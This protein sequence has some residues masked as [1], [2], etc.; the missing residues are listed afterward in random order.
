MTQGHSCPQT[1]SGRSPPQGP[2]GSLP[3]PT[4]QV[5]GV[6]GPG[7]QPAWGPAPSIPPGPS[8]QPAQTPGEPA[9][10]RCTLLGG[11]TGRGA[12][13]P[14]PTPASPPPPAPPA[15]LSPLGTGAEASISPRQ[16]AGV[17]SPPGRAGTASPSPPRAP[18]ARQGRSFS[19]K[20]Q[21]D[22][23]R[24]HHHRA[25]RLPTRGGERVRGNKPRGQARHGAAVARAQLSLLMAVLSPRSKLSRSAAP[26]V[27]STCRGR[28]ASRGRCRPL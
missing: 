7:P 15:N 16:P 27:S 25:D 22:G 10:G 5:K 14:A 19:C 20:R 13:G 8:P 1:W 9:M 23:G 28:R 17:R 3:S 6:W 18:A 11:N 4:P 26:P 12:V 21:Q 24:C 2:Q